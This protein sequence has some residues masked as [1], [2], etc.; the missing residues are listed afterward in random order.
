MIWTYR[1]FDKGGR[2]TVMIL[3]WQNLEVNYQRYDWTKHPCT[4]KLKDNSFSCFEKQSIFIFFRTLYLEDVIRLWVASNPKWAL[5][6]QQALDL[7]YLQVAPHL[8][9][10]FLKTWKV[11]LP[12]KMKISKFN[13]T[14]FSG[15]VFDVFYLCEK[16][17][18]AVRN[19]NCWMS[20]NWIRNDL[21]MVC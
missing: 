9:Y 13:S 4:T 6:E 7:R 1:V 8:N 16:A 3:V 21:S 19:V 15:N 12:N 17:K 10:C 5:T 11:L 20:C 18:Y 14:V 2:L